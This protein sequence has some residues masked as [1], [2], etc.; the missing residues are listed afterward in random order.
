[1]ISQIEKYFADV[2]EKCCVDCRV[3]AFWL[4]S[5][6]AHVPAVSLLTGKGNFDL[7]LVHDLVL[8]L[9]I[10]LHVMLQLNS[11]N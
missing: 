10:F 1:M 6:I 11:D 5:A 4:P 2:S 7:V 8:C 9:Q 3:I